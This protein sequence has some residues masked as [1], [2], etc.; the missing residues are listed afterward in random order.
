M[1]NIF[2][3]HK[4]VKK[5]HNIKNHCDICYKTYYQ[6]KFK[7]KD[8][9]KKVFPFEFGVFAFF[10]AQAVVIECF[11]TLKTNNLTFIYLININN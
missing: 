9:K 3:P 8:Q 10:E 2:D 7:R 1:L 11:I 6:P 5:L 4:P